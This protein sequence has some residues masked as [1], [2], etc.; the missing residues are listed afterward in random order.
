MGRGTG[1]RCSAKGAT[2]DSFRTGN[3]DRE[4][5]GAALAGSGGVMKILLLN[6]HLLLRQGLRL[7]LA[8]QFP[9]AVFGEARS[10][11]ESLPEILREPWDVAILGI[12]LPGRGVLEVLKAMRQLRGE[13]PVLVL[14]LYSEDQFALRLLKAGASGYLTRESTG[15]DLAAA[16]RAALNGSRYIS[17]E[18]ADRMTSTLYLEAQQSPHER[19]S[20]REFMILR[21]IASGKMVGQIARELSLSVSTVS[22]YRK[23]IL[24]KMRMANSA[25][26]TH[27]AVQHGLVE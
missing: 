24:G 13:L 26:L 18:L 10:N 3:F 21:L 12:S 17:P 5:R 19:L 6:D 25:Q 9:G 4:S 7:I 20:N 14:S 15:D 16:I 11:A 2:E 23:R 1:L 22:T 27:Y 8:V